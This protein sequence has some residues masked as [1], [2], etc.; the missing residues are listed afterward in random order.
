MMH[1]KVERALWKLVSCM[2]AS[3]SLT[4]CSMMRLVGVAILAGAKVSPETVETVCS[5]REG[6]EER[7]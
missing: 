3:V 5:M 1:F 6:Q 7:P 2:A 4:L